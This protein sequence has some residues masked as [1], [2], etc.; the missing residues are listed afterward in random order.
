MTPHSCQGLI[1]IVP[2]R[3]EE[4]TSSLRLKC[5][6]EPRSHAGGANQCFKPLT[7]AVVAVVVVVLPPVFGVVVV[8][9]V[10]VVLVVVVVVTSSNSSG[11]S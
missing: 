5:G 8:I 2:I 4:S 10:I 7:L 9:V 1:K 3:R 11:S 6:A